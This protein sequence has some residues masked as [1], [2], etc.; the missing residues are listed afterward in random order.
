MTET[1]ETTKQAGDSTIEYMSLF[2][3]GISNAKDKFFSGLNYAKDNLYHP[4]TSETRVSV[5][6]MLIIFFLFI[7]IS[8]YLYDTYVKKMLDTKYVENKE[9]TDRNTK[10][11][12]D[13]YFFYTNW[14]PHCKKSRPE[15]KLLKKK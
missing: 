6:V 11:Q 1:G 5:F 8:Y 4:G 13:F 12:I 15:W 3:N 2:V 9:F 10:K 14:C 7:G